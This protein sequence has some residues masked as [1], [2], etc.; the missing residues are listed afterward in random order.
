MTPPSLTCPD[1]IEVGNDPGKNFGHVRIPQPK[2]LSDNTGVVPTLQ[3]SPSDLTDVHP[4]TVRKD[5][6]KIKYTAKDEAGLTAE[7]E[8]EVKVK[9]A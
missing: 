3:L 5:P 4:F 9:G 2:V 7:C 1:K 8:F 6:H